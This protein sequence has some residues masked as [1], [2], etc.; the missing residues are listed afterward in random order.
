MKKVIQGIAAGVLFFAMPA[1]VHAEQEISFEE[2]LFVDGE[3]DVVL[4]FNE[5]CWSV[6]TGESH[7]GNAAV[8]GRGHSSA[9]L[10]GFG[11]SSPYMYV[12]VP[13]RG[14]LSFWWKA[15]GGARGSV[16][17]REEN[18]CNYQEQASISTLVEFKPDT[19][20]IIYRDSDWMH[21]SL[22]CRWNEGARYEIDASAGK[23]GECLLLDE[24]SWTPAPGEVTI[25][26]M[27]GK[28]AWTDAVL[29]PESA[30]YANLA[31]PTR[32]G[33]VFGGWYLDPEFGKKAEGQL[34]YSGAT[35][36][37]KWYRTLAAA[38]TAEM[39]FRNNPAAY[40]EGEWA[41]Y[42]AYTASEWNLVERTYTDNSNIF[43]AELPEEGSEGMWWFG[44]YAVMEATVT[45]SCFL[46]FVWNVTYGFSNLRFFVDGEERKH[47]TLFAFDG[48]N[49]GAKRVVLDAGMHTLRWE[50]EGSDAVANIRDIRKVAYTPAATLGEWFWRYRDMQQCWSV[51]SLS[52]LKAKYGA[53]EQAVGDAGYKAAIERAASTVL[54]LGEDKLVT[55]TFGHFGFTLHYLNFGATGAFDYSNAPVLN[56]T[57]D[58]A[59]AKAQPELESALADLE[60]IPSGWTGHVLISPNEYPVDSEMAIDYGDVLYLKALLKGALGAAHWVKAYNVEVDWAK[61]EG[62]FR[63]PEVFAAPSAPSLT[64]DEGWGNPVDFLKGERTERKTLF[65]DE[66][67]VDK[68]NPGRAGQFR[69]ARCGNA[70]YIRIPRNQFTLRNLAVLGGSMDVRIV[71][72]NGMLGGNRNNR[73]ESIRIQFFDEG[74]EFL[75]GKKSQWI[76]WDCGTR[77][78]PLAVQVNDADYT[79]A[80]DLTESDI[81]N[82]QSFRYVDNLRVESEVTIGQSYFW[83]SMES[84]T[85]EYE[86]CN[87]LGTVLLDQTKAFNK[88]RNKAELSTSKGYVREA[89]RLAQSADAY[90]VY[91][92][93]YPGVC[94]F[95]YDDADANALQV[96]REQL[97]AAI[98]SL[99]A[100]V[101]VSWKKGMEKHGAELEP[102]RNPIK[103][104]LGALFEGKVTQS[105]IPES[106]RD[107][108]YIPCLDTMKDPTF[109]GLLPDFTRAEWATYARIN[110]ILFRYVPTE[111]LPPVAKP[112]DGFLYRESDT[113][114]DPA[115]E[116]A[117]YANAAAVYDGYLLDAEG[118]MIGMLQVKVSKGKV[119]KNTGVLGAKVTATL[120]PADGSKKV[121]FKN[122]VA[123]ATGAVT[124]L[125]A[126]N[127]QTLSLSLGVFGLGGV[128][129]SGLSV[130]GAR[131]LFNGKSAEDKA[132]AAALQEAYA[133]TYNLVCDEGVVS[134]SVAKKGKAKVSGTWNGVK[135]SANSQLL[136]G[137]GYC[138]VPVVINKKGAALAF[139]LWLQEGAA[140]S[141]S[142]IDCRAVG[143]SGA[144][145]SGA[146]FRMDGAALA[147]VLPGLLTDYLPGGLSVAQSGTKWV[148]AGGAKAGKLKL[149]KGSP[150]A[151]REKSKFSDNMSG[152]KLTYK[153]K[154]G[155]FKGSFKAYAV[156]K[157]KLKSYTVNV[158][159]VMV[160]DTG[161]GTAVLKKPAVSFP[162]M[163]K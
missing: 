138:T 69:V 109:G 58:Q 17:G 147:Q 41:S 72:S 163:V 71:L 2:A 112:E 44:S 98:A 143:F 38:D 67:T 18:L 101:Y 55:D 75:D 90:I 27:T 46:D 74:M 154:D 103:F 12:T 118:R 61:V 1:A 70:L 136:P 60:R 110:D 20:E 115:T 130:T 59:V 150:E 158:T 137:V 16:Y 47:G 84:S 68:A 77:Y 96:A 114:I 97:A 159:G 6:T 107:D 79:I 35:V 43:S 37:A 57:V 94:L 141:V 26:C 39:Q 33:Y 122:G 81:G 64:S 95:N 50:A 100:E 25:R 133:G 13:G 121:S 104:Y 93:N 119:D 113:R 22:D 62:D 144:L 129:G 19:Y 4:N 105:L 106:T 91:N 40:S 120:T 83:W 10:C 155:S 117:P 34:P 73:R 148:V 5:D 156:E 24:M 7:D 99:D 51:N 157:N 31:P 108:Y 126:S 161:Y 56:A 65:D 142:G 162:I 30:T 152:L 87:R 132:L 8:V 66:E 11:S 86:A 82:D 139:N 76:T 54:A 140:P 3:E 78:E 80:I 151:D 52:P 28:D 160:G 131:N 116:T 88:I 21:V 127:G 23:D 111:Y 53:A 135:I 146:A 89:L 29:D 125:S 102:Y 85:L 153:A 15:K 49:E 149:L 48:A 32:A 9:D 36:Y 128:T 123:D 45:G 14:T 42:G 124:V 92:R 63:G 134:V 145:K